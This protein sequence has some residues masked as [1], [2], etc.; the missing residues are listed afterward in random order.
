MQIK[1]PVVLAQM[2]A[3]KILACLVHWRESYHSASIHAHTQYTVQCFHRPRLT[4]TGVAL[5][6]GKQAVC[7]LAMQSFA[8]WWMQHRTITPPGIPPPSAPY[9]KTWLVI[10]VPHAFAGSGKESKHH[11][12]TGCLVQARQTL[13]TVHRTL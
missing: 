11:D 4:T 6:I 10:S 2:S 9:T 13:L 12:K 5:E 1:K 7:T 3:P 8:K